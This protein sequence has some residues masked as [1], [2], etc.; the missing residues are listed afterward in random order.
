[1]YDFIAQGIGVVAAALT[2]LSF[3]F[4]K[5]KSLYLLQAVSGLLFSINFLMLGAYTAACLN[6]INLFRGG[7]LAGGDRFKSNWLAAALMAAYTAVTV[8]TY[9]N[10]LSVLV[11]VAQLVGTVAMWS[12]K[13][14][15]IRLGQ[16]FVVSPSWLIHNVFNFS[17]GGL[18]T[19]AVS[20]VSILISLIRY[21]K[22]FEETKQT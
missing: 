20:I 14:R 12:R 19:E 2:I 13:G 11:L 10:W 22:G 15:I 18:I 9:A 1:M 16:L 21:R 8:V 17:L 5:N 3:Q 4:K 6:F 7:L